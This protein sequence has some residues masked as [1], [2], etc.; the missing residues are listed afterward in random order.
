MQRSF[1]YKKTLTGFLLV[2]GFIVYQ[3][4][5]SIYLLLPPMLGVLFFYFM[6]AL[7]RE[8]LSK[9]LLVIVL[10]LVFEAEKDFLLFSSLVYFTFLYRFVIPRL[11]VMISCAACLKVILIVLAYLG[12][13]FFSYILNQVLWVEL[14]SMDWHILYYMIVELLLVFAL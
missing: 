6:Y 13:V 1:A 4:L 11:R 7:E 8:D 3:S 2:I 14:P 12:Y 9:L 10:L 5:S